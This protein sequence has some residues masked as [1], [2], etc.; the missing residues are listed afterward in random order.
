[1]IR[2]FWSEAENFNTN[3]AKNAKGDLFLQLPVIFF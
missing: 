3:E 1:M 2:V